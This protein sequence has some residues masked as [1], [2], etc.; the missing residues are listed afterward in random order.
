[1]EIVPCSRVGHVYKQVL[2]IITFTI[3]TIIIIIIIIIIAFT[4]NVCKKGFYTTTQ[5]EDANK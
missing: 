2:V 4:C 5:A 3:I 1:M